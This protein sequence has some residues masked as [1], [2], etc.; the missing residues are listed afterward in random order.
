MGKAYLESKATAEL[1]QNFID[2]ITRHDLFLE[3][4]LGS[5]VVMK[6]QIPG[7]SQYR[8]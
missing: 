7:A 6:T 8:H 5:G 3:T 1:C 4:N 2:M